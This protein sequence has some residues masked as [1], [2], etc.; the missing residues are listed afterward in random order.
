MSLEQDRE[1]LLHYRTEATDIGIQ[2]PPLRA[3]I[4]FTSRDNNTKTASLTMTTNGNGSAPIA[5]ASKR[6]S[7]DSL[8]GLSPR[9]S[10]KPR[11]DEKESKGAY[12]YVWYRCKL[13]CL[14][15]PLSSNL[16]LHPLPIVSNI[17]P[18]IAFALV[19]FI[20]FQSHDT[21]ILQKTMAF[22]SPKSRNPTSPFA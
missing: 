4:V 6:D 22:Q 19:T 20:F 17:V 10:K 8:A 7:I 9:L 11:S 21:F 16:L 3:S 5:L 18:F 13:L 15:V 12:H 1:N 2:Q 14:A